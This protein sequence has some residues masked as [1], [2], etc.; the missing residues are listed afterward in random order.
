MNSSKKLLLSLSD[1]EW[2]DFFPEDLREQL[3]K[4]FPGYQRVDSLSLT[5]DSWRKLLSAEQPDVLI[6]CWKTPSLP[7]DVVELTNGRLKY[8]CFLAGSVRK[9]VSDSLI[10]DGLVVTNWGSSISRT[11]AEC[12][13]MMSIACLRRA[14]TWALDMHLNGAWK[15]DSLVSHSLFERKV[16][17]HGFGA[18]SREL[19]RLLVPFEVRIASFSPSVPDHLL[20]EFGVERSHSLADLFSHNDVIFELAALTPD[21]HHIVDESL[22]R[23][24][25]D[26]GVFINIGRGAVVDEEALLRVAKDKKI[27]IGLDVF[28]EEPLPKDHPFRGQRNIMLLPHLGGPSIDRRQDSGRMA[29]RNLIAFL[30]GEPLEGVI[31]PTVYA[32]TT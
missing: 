10:N 23:R 25:P 18:I 22:L 2:R 14:H 27:Q 12:G 24:I 17:I 16:G 31:S 3:S 32:R 1:I 19:C 28:T 15:D 9:F 8:A 30:K 29:I 20:E 5:D 21:N 26:D 6:A 13:L 11:V 7:E 4:L